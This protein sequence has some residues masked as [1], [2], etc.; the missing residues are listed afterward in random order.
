MEYKEFMEEIERHIKE[1][2][3]EEWKNAEVS[4]RQQLK[5]NGIQLYGMGIRIPGNSVTPQIYLDDAYQS[6][7]NGASMEE[8]LKKLAEQYVKSVETAPKLGIHTFNYENWKDSLFMCAVNAEKNRELLSSVPHQIVEDLAVVY[9]CMIEEDAGIFGSVLV[10]NDHLKCWNIDSEM[11]HE[12][13]AKSMKRLMPY[14]F[15]S[16]D[17]VI[18]DMMGSPFEESQASME[19]SFMF[20]LSNSKKWQGA[21][22]LFCPDVLE[23]VSKELGGNYLIL[24]SSIHE[25]ILIREDKDKEIK[26]LK[27]IVCDVNQSQVYEEERLS[28][29]V[30]RYDAETGSISM[31]SDREMQ[32]GMH[33]DM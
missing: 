13:T 10:N 17:Y 15:H 27:D 12:Q 26:D 1:Y 5:N 25:L 28:N 6:Y 18:A 14:E 32:Q 21:S 22:Y 30:Y 31:A 16:M 24:P 4:V 7:S 2:L 8:I 11:L 20:V 29:E 3:P 9:R 19:N 23:A 33:L